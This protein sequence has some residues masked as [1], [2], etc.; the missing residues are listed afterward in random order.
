MIYTG[1]PYDRDKMGAI[2]ERG[3][4]VD[5]S[6]VEFPTCNT[7]DEN[8][9]AMFVYLRNTGFENIQFD[10]V[11]MNYEQK[12]ALLKAYLSTNIE[13]NIPALNDTWMSVLYA[14]LEM[15]IDGLPSIMNELE[16][17]TMQSAEYE[18]ILKLWNF[19]VSL[20]LFLIKRLDLDFET[21]SP[22]TDEELNI[23]N[24]YNIFEHENFDDLV[25]RTAGQLPMRDYV[26]YFT[27]ENTRLFNSLHNCSFTVFLQ[28]IAS[29]KDEEFKD[30]VMEL[31][32]KVN[33]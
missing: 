16:L 14:C 12:V 10:Y 21:T 29:S 33:G 7:L 5:L 4:T 20:P 1:L 25:V 8:Y 31:A 28:G 6:K 24:L 9:M 22:E 18:Y 27:I 32:E 2:Y 11:N 17:I 3:A 19:I 13:Y 15:K 26:K 23:V 30:F